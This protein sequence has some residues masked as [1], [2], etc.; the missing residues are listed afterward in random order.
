MKTVKY[1]NHKRTLNTRLI[2]GIVVGLIVVAIIGIKIAIG[3]RYTGGAGP[4][5][6]AGERPAGA[7]ARR[8]LTRGVAQ[9]PA[10]MRVP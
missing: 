6:H 2:L 7:L 10:S 8:G 3:Q 5:D 9:S 1:Q 4:G